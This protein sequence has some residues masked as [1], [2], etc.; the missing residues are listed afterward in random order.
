MVSGQQNK[1][2][3]L[4]NDNVVFPCPHQRTP[5]PVKHERTVHEYKRKVMQEG[6]CCCYRYQCYIYIFPQGSTNA[7]AT[8]RLKSA[9]SAAMETD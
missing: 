1:P 7:E 3:G 8:H 9:H 2:T 5:A 4:I 6:L